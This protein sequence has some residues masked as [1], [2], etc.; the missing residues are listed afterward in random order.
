MILRYCA[1]KKNRNEFALTLFYQ[2]AIFFPLAILSGM[3]PDSPGYIVTLFMFT[4]FFPAFFFSSYSFFFSKI[5]KKRIRISWRKIAHPTLFA[6]VIALGIGLIGLQSA[7]PTLVISIFTT[8]GA[9]T[10]P[11]LM[12]I[13]GGSVYINYQ[14]QGITD[15]SE[16]MKFV[17]CKN[18]IFPLIFIGILIFLKSTIPRSVAFIILLQSAVPPVTAVPMV[19]QRM[20]GNFQLVSQFTVASFLFSLI[21]IPIMVFLYSIFFPF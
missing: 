4:I 16:T 15:I 7:V 17:I 2:N 3:F 12:I 18:I 13:L 20:N 9:M 21:S 8:L 6:T 11:L 19:T 10:V 1:Q 5:Q 14:K